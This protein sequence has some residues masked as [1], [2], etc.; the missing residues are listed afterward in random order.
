MSTTLLPPVRTLPAPSVATADGR[1]DRRV[2]ETGVWIA[3][4]TISMSF[5][6]LTSAL[7]VRQSSGLDWQHLQ[8]L[9]HLRGR[10]A[11]QAL[12]GFTLGEGVGDLE[13]P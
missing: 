3:I 2:A 9:D 12:S 4:G 1:P 13:K 10:R 11:G 7:V 6:A 5:A 8:P